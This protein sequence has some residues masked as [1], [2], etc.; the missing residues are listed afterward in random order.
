[1][2]IGIKSS[3]II[4]SIASWHSRTLNVYVS[5][6]ASA[7]QRVICEKYS[8]DSLSSSAALLGS[9][10]SKWDWKILHDLRYLIMR[11]ELD[12]LEFIK[13]LLWNIAENA[14]ALWLGELLSS[15]LDLAS[16]KLT[17]RVVSGRGLRVFFVKKAILIKVH[18]RLN[19]IL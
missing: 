19:L 6:V 17:D 7:R 5:P 14:L 4:S 10:K 16:C 11:R 8:S 9:L 15:K 12:I 3:A 1:M 13:A 18:G 2:N